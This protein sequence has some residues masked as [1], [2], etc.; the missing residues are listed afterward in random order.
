MEKSG[1][2][3]EKNTVCCVKKTFE[4]KMGGYQEAAPIV[5]VS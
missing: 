4:N 3:F 1:L 2:R 5:Q